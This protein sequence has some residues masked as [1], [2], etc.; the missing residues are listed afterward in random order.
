MSYDSSKPSGSDP[1][2]SS[3]DYL[4][5]NFRALKEDKIVNALKVNGYSPGNGSGNIPI[6]NNTV[7]TQ[8]N[9]DKVDGYDAGNDDGDVPISNG[10][11]NT[12][13]NSDLLDGQHGSYYRDVDN[14]NAGT[15]DVDRG[16]TGISSY[17]KGGI[18]TATGSTTLVEKSV[19]SNGEIIIADSSEDEGWKWG[20]LN[21]SLI[22]QL[23]NPTADEQSCS[24][25]LP[26]G[27]TTAEI[28]LLADSSPTST[29]TVQFYK[30]DV[31]LDSLNISSTAANKASVNSLSEDDVLY[32]KLS[33][34]PYGISKLTGQIKVS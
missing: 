14:A 30:N 31:L 16:G 19:G 3:D 32:M 24:I 21:H 5:E 26:R 17:T 33:G 23:L 12:N 34:S 15:L 10:T 11:V 20:N 22:F 2:G 7:C 6:N 8:L 18:I 27:F 28:D 13:L 29:A 9:A 4:R 25:K 1:I